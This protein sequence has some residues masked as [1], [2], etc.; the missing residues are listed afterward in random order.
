V[1]QDIS[2]PQELL[3]GK[4][5]VAWS[6]LEHSINEI[7]WALLRVS[8]EDGRIITA[9]LDTR[10]RLNLLRALGDRRLAEIDVKLLSD[11]IKKIN[12]LNEYRN[13]IVHGLWV[14]ILPDDAPAV[15]SLRGKLPDD[16]GANEV[17]T[18]VMSAELM[19]GVIDRIVFMMNYLIN[20]RE[21]LH[22]Y[23][24]KPVLPVWTAG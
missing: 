11:L 16:A 9:S 12:E 10:Y 2:G 6:R 20:V 18:T 21:T 4:A 3:I 5:V 8:V 7:I 1:R 22:S 19:H 24:D 15:Q 14:T 23:P 17:V 13:L